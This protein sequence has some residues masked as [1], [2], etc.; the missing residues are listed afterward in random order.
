MSAALI[1]LGGVIVGLV[2]GRAY[3]Y[4]STRRSELAA[5]VIATAVV[6]EELRRYLLSEN[7]ADVG[8][9][10]E[11][12]APAIAGA[13]VDIGVAADVE[14]VWRDHRVALIPFMNPTD[15][16]NLAAS[17]PGPTQK[18]LSPF[19][20]RDLISRLDRLGEL[21]WAQHEALIFVPFLRYFR[22]DTVSKR[23]HVLLD[24][25]DDGHAAPSQ[26]QVR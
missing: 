4:W 24:T 17:M 11:Y 2:F 15:Y 19:S 14:S 1:G 18:V 8:E 12:K 16:R 6:A 20:P 9:A 5:G 10:E 3:A 7:G 22:G 25:D 21:L 26:G 13:V 23:I